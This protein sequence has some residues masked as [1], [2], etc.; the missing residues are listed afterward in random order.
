MSRFLACDPAYPQNRQ[1]EGAQPRTSGTPA[2]N[3]TTV[4]VRQPRTDSHVRI[5]LTKPDWNI[6]GGF[7]FVTRRL[8]DTLE[9]SG[10]SV[11]SASIPGIADDRSVRGVSV[12]DNVWAA[13]PEF[14]T[15]ASL[16][17]RFQGL[18]VSD[19]DLVI[20]TQ[21][22]SWGVEH[23]HKLAVFYHHHRV[24]YDLEKTV[25]DADLANSDLHPI[26][27]Q[28][29][30]E[31]D[32][33]SI[34]SISHFLVPSRT[35]ASRL[36]AFNGIDPSK[37]SPYHAGPYHAAGDFETTAEHVLCVSRSE[38]TKRTELFV[39]AAHCGFEAPA[40]LIGSGGRLNFTKKYA[41][42]RCADIEREAD[43]WWSP[44]GAEPDDS[45]VPHDPV[46]IH[47]WLD[48]GAVSDYY[49]S[50]SVVV[51]P[52]FNEDYGLTVLEAMSYG[53]PVIVCDDGGG[54]VELVEH[55]V[56][57][58]VVAPTAAAIATAARSITQDSQRATE[59]G[60]A[61]LANAETYTWDRAA[62]QLLDGVAT[63]MATS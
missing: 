52:A 34:E 8:L 23:P 17:D 9:A 63:V 47:G 10:H 16:L 12:P 59:M 7:E 42:D 40:H 50:A 30:R 36:E 58:L 44:T 19:A 24:C 48:D 51:A 37:T 57:G 27:S 53:K 28:M 43:P 32:A 3:L 45:A 11:R 4:R 1:P 46:A 26:A 22:G 35:V 20:T 41:A 18:D 49:A 2:A 38:F 56:T 29:L 31:L 21:P 62:K 5:V 54:L 6:T 60:E 61:A 55:G 15:Y 39:A 33:P 25:V 13:A 14:F